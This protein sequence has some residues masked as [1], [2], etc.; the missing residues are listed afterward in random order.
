MAATGTD[1]PRPLEITVQPD[2]WGQASPRD[3]QAVVTSAARQIWRHCS[4]APP[5]DPIR[6][7]RSGSSPIAIFQREPDGAIIVRLASQDTYWSQFAYQ[8]AHEFGHVMAVHGGDWRRK[9][10]NTTHANKWF[11]ESLCE[12]ASLFALRAMAREWATNAPYPNWKSYAPNLRR[13]ADNLLAEPDRQ[14]PAGESFAAWFAR[15]QPRLRTN[16]VQR[17]LNGLVAAQLLPLFEEDPRHW[18]AALYLNLDTR[19][20]RKPFRQ[21]LAEWQAACPARHHSFIRRVAAVFG[22]AL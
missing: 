15:T 5:L 1:V 13:Y 14:L 18:E 3:I 9:W 10:Q 4:N 11:E 22:I 17:P 12:A 6:V 16:A 7:K 8:F 19:D 2:A 21:F 20:E